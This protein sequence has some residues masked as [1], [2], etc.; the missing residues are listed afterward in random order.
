M[1]HKDNNSLNNYY[2]NLYWCTQ[3]ENSEQMVRD[4]R[5]LK[6][7]KNPNWKDKDME[8]IFES[9]AKGEGIISISKFLR[10][11]KHTVSKLIQNKFKELWQQRKR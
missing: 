11:S 1:G 9:Y 4:G 3:K 7:N 8:T 6:G 10:L 5:S 2:K